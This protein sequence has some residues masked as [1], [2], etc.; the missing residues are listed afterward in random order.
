[1]L[2]SFDILVGGPQD[3]RNLRILEPGWR[4]FEALFK[5]E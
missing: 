2:R 1:M 4:E 5:I 3:D